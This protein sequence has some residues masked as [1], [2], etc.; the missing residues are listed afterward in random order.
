M[1]PNDGRVVSNFIVQALRGQ[2]ITLYGDGSQTRS[3][4]YVDDLIEAIVRLMATGSDVT[5]PINLQSDR[6][7]DQATRESRLR[8]LGL[9]RRSPTRICP[10]MIPNRDDRISLWLLRCLTGRRQFNSL[11]AWRRPSRI[12]KPS[13][14]K[15][16]YDHESLVLVRRHPRIGGIEKYNRDFIAALRSAGV[17]VCAVERRAGGLQSP[18]C[19]KCIAR[20]VFFPAELLGLRVC[21]FFRWLYCFI[22]LRV[23]VI[24]CRFMGSKRSELVIQYI[25]KPLGVLIRSL[26][27]PN[28][29]SS[30][31]TISS[32]LNLTRCHADQFGG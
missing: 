32:I 29:P 21:I 18:I 14:A 2:P 15:R 22:F 30:W 25:G 19:F 17:E 3:F 8:K 24:R 10:K 4:C 12:L 1:H 6:I 27:Y 23:C 28:I 31:S 11:K 20:P 16:L 26:L 5:G 9:H 13:T 7:H